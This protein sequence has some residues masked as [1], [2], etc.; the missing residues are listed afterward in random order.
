MRLIVL[1]HHFQGINT[2]VEGERRVGFCVEGTG[3]RIS[4]E[5]LLHLFRWFYRGS[6]GHYFGTPG[7]DLG[8]AI[9]KHVVDH[10]QGWIEVQ[11]VANGHAAR[12]TVWIPE[13]NTGYRLTDLLFPAPSARLELVTNGFEVLQ[14]ST[15]IL[16]PIYGDYTL[17]KRYSFYIWGTHK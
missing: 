1:I 9:E 14:E 7:M 11:N 13:K 15:Y 2:K 17:K 12:F 5:D 3:L 8:L 10:H 6:V 16:L 4:A